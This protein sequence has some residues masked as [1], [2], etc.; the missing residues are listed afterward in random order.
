[1]LFLHILRLQ[2]DVDVF[3]VSCHFEYRFMLISE[4]YCQTAPP[5]LDIS[6]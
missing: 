6:A 2:I 3:A 5:A 1:M 4:Q